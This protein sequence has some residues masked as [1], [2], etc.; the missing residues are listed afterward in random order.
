MGRSGDS[1]TRVSGVKAK[2]KLPKNLW[3]GSSTS[4]G[5]NGNNATY[6]YSC[7]TLIS[8]NLER[9]VT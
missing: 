5:P 4:G 6:T 1:K 3:E 9:F 7:T 2:D 8:Q